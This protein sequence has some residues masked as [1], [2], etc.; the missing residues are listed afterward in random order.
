[1]TQALW[2]FV[3]AMVLV[4]VFPN[5]LHAHDARYGLATFKAHLNSVG[6]IW[7]VERDTGRVVQCYPAKSCVNPSTAISPARRDK[8]EQDRH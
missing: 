8:D 1:M 2:C 5:Y 6:I 7:L 4:L 3:V